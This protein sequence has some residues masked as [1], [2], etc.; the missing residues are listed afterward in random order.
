MKVPFNFYVI[1]LPQL[2]VMTQ[3]SQPAV[4]TALRCVLLQVSSAMSQKV[5]EDVVSLWPDCAMCLGREQTSD[6]I[7]VVVLKSIFR[8]LSLSQSP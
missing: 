4:R 6:K 8:V 2:L 1:L 5:H 3:S 7:P